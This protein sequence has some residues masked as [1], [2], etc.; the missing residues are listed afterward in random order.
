MPIPPRRAF[1]KSSGAV[2]AAAIAVPSTAIAQPAA[3][4]PPLLEAVAQ[5][6]L[7][8][9]IGAAGVQEALRDFVRWL[10]GFQPVAEL[11][12]PYLSSDRIPYGPPDPAP[13]WNSQLEALDLL[14]RRR[15][16]QGFADLPIPLRRE[17]LAGELDRLAPQG[18]MPAAPAAAAHVA[19]GL[20]ARYAS[21]PGTADLAYRARIRARSCRSLASGA[22]RPP[23]LG[24]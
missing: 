12:H 4:D 15:H 7:P 24:V 10:D 1:L 20:L 19:V 11:N 5:A 21:R 13:M 16:Q 18:E 8:E 9:E 3:L 2:A 22:E 6:T 14:A 17:L 23:A